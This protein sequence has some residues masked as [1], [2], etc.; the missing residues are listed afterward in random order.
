F[1]ANPPAGVRRSRLAGPCQG[2]GL[3]ERRPSRESSD[4]AVII[5]TSGTT[6]LPKGAWFDHAG[7]R[8]AVSLSGEMSAPFERKFMPTPFAHAGFMAKMWEQIAFAITI[9][10]PPAPWTAPDM[11]RLM[12]RERINVAAGVPTQWDKLMALPAVD[13]G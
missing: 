4:P 8:A 7:L 9:V 11:L 12:V 5:W 1:P 6:G 13:V 3:G 2:E 10:I